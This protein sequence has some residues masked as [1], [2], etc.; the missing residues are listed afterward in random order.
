MSNRE[1]Y[2]TWVDEQGRVRYSPIA[3]SPDSGSARKP[4][5]ETETETE[6]TLENYPDADQLS[7]DG[8]VRPGERPPYFTW[9]DAEGNVRVSYYQPDTRADEEKGQVKP[10][11]ELTPASVYHA[12]PEVKLAEPVSGSDPDAFA[13]LG[14]EP[15]TESF[16]TR[17]EKSCCQDL[18]TEDHK[19]WQLGREFGF[20]ITEDSPV[21]DFMTGRSP[22]QLVA[23]SSVITHPDFIMRVR[24]YTKGGV[25]APS[26]L[27]L[28]R[29]FAPVRLVTDLVSEYEPENWHRRGYLESWIPVF[30]SEG[31]RW[32]VFFTRD[33]DLVGQEVIETRRGLKAIPHASVGEIGLMMA[34]ED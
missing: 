24:S 28:D 29:D 12:G 31:E 7:K 10:P 14:I 23:L 32:V 30:P 13:V 9:R 34:E 19:E 15:G 4:E 22:Y 11:I 16:F 20:Y 21:H 5:T 3:E 6:Y 33:Q 8:Y 25:F 18:D 1:G 26:L 2:F 27:F 17:F